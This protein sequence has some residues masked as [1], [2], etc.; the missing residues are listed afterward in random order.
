MFMYMYSY[1]YMLYGRMGRPQYGK[2]GMQAEKEM[3]KQC[4]E[5]NKS[6]TLISMNKT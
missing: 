3:F 5:G 4:G 1:M 2:N 6:L